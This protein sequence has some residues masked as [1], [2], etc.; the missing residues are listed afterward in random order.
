MNVGERIRARRKEKKISQSRL[1]ELIGE[2]GG[3]VIANWEQGRSEPSID[4]TQRAAV[5]LETTASML[6][7]EEQRFPG[8]IARIPVYENEAAAG[9]GCENEEDRLE[10]YLTIREDL[11]RGELGAAPG[12]LCVIRI[13][14]DSMTPTIS[15]GE[16]VILNHR[17][18]SVGTDGV[19]VIRMN[20]ALLV[21]RIQNLP[22]KLV[23]I[24]DN[25]SYPAW[26]VETKDLP[27]DFKVLGRVIAT[28]TLRKL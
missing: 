22:G 17:E 18:N 8:N 24:S 11:V 4:Q 25:P 21:K 20:G 3:Y 27:G 9:T 1:A 12:D 2:K 16:M 6:I 7:E 13:R 19:Y 23:I 5:A 10:N 15:P 26:T 28:V 14:G